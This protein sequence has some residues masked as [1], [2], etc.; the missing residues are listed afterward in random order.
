MQEG[1]VVLSMRCNTAVLSHL[2]NTQTRYLQ[3]RP[4]DHNT[5][6]KPVRGR[7][8]V[9]QGKPHVH[10][11]HAKQHVYIVQGR[12]AYVKQHVYIARGRDAYAN[13]NDSI[14]LQT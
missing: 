3:P 10:K 13:T 12:D 7:V 6:S 9:V 1:L 8:C 14:S 2:F 11:S 4:E 5:K